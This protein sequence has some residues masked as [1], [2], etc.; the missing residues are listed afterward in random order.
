MPDFIIHYQE[1]E[2]VWY[3]MNSSHAGL[4]QLLNEVASKD[5]VT[6]GIR[7]H[8]WTFQPCQYNRDIKQ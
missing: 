1:N 8:L 7:N 6:A 4:S 3:D 2:V 5:Y